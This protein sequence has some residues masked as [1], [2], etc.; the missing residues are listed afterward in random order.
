MGRI[1]AI[2][3]GQ[4]RTG[5]DPLK[6]IANALTTIPTSD[7]FNFITHYLISNKVELFVVG[8]PLQ[9]NNKPSSAIK[10]ID[11]FINNLKKKYPEIPVE[12]ED[13]RFTSSI[14]FQA[15][16]DGGLKKEKRKDK[17]I[18]D[19]ISATLI[20]QSYMERVSKLQK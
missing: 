16:L 1:I 12:L 5:T 7:F 10:Y 9:L 18:I 3:Y 4:K 13:E 11:K 17:G 8:Y 19:R 20:L 2:D 6:I 15:M 14:A